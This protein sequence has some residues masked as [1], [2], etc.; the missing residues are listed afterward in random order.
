VGVRPE[1]AQSMVSLNIDLGTIETRP[2]LAVA[3]QMLRR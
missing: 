2:T 3:L 1:I